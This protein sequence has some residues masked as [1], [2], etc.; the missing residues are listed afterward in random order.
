[1]PTPPYVWR[2]LDRTAALRKRL[3]STLSD[4]ARPPVAA[5]LDVE[6]ERRGLARRE[7]REVRA[8]RRDLR[9]SDHPDAE[10]A[11]DVA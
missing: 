1:M 7:D 9:A 6:H 10:T 2:S 8:L 3:P 4:P 5:A 11:C